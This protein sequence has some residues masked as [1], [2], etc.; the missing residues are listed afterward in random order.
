MRHGGEIKENA[1]VL[2]NLIGDESDPRHR[3]RRRRGSR[4]LRGAE[5][6][7]TVL[8]GK[9][10]G[11]YVIRQIVIGDRID[12]ERGKSGHHPRCRRAAVAKRTVTVL[13]QCQL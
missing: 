11:I 12:L 6:A 7:V 5:T 9:Q 2:I 8:E 4:R 3:C 13:I 10:A 1:A